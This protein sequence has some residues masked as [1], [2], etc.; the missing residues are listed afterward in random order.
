MIASSWIDPNS[1]ITNDWKLVFGLK[2]KVL[3]L[4]NSLGGYVAETLAIKNDLNAHTFNAPGFNNIVDGDCKY[5]YSDKISSHK[6]NEDQLVIWVNHIVKW[7]KFQWKLKIVVDYV[8]LKILEY[9][10]SH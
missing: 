9:Q 3:Y 5:K 8:L 1:S 6:T 2:V 4:P 10:L 7:Q